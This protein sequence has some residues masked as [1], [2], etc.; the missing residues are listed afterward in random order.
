MIK[1][2]PE[3]RGRYFCFS[4]FS[5]HGI[6][7]TENCWRSNEFISPSFLNSYWKTAEHLFQ[8]FKTFDQEWI[9]RIQNAKVPSD[10]KSLGRGAQLRNDWNRVKD[11]VMYFT[12][13]EKFRQNTDIQKILLETE[14][15]QLVEGNTWGD[16]Y[17]GVS[18]NSKHGKNMLGII[19]MKIREEINNGEI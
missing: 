10:A 9:Q 5:K 7:L 16:N 13:R 15:A 14:D 8:S 17:W 18:R 11:I 3:F 19:L 2:V 4:N 6:W 1:I 12:V